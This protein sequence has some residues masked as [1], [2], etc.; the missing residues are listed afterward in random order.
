MIKDFND[1]CKYVNNESLYRE[2]KWFN[3]YW[4]GIGSN[5]AKNEIYNYCR[6][7]ARALRAPRD[8]KG[9]FKPSSYCQR[10][11]NV[12]KQFQFI[13]KLNEQKDSKTALFGVG[14]ISYCGAC[15]CCNLL[16][17]SSGGSSGRN[18]FTLPPID[19]KLSFTNNIN[20]D[21]TTRT[22]TT[23]DVTEYDYVTTEMTEVEDG[24]FVG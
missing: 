1:V 18:T 2:S 20:E 12:L 5:E 11:G 24:I 4:S 23:S 6:E 9:G 17:G 14:L 22:T 13:G 10:V 21:T 3:Q 16:R 19:D 8:R 15:E 7:S